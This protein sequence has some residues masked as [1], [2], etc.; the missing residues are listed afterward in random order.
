VSGLTSDGVGVRPDL[1]VRL[2]G[3]KQLVVDA[4]A[5]LA[6]FLDAS[7]E[8]ASDQQREERLR[9]HGRALRG[10]VDALAAR[11][12][13][14]AFS[15]APDVV[16]CFVPGESMLAAA[17]DADPGLHEHGLARGVVLA[18]PGTLLAL[19]RTV[20]FTWQQ[21]ALAGNARELFEVGRELYARLGTLGS[22][23][24]KLGRTLHRAV[25]DYNALVGTLERR[26]LVTARRI[27]ELEVADE[28]IPVTQPVEVT[29]RPLTAG[30]L[31]EDLGARPELL[32]DAGRA[33]P[34]PLFEAESG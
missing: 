21:E 16:V 4:K 10:H 3:G 33:R 14:R 19:L 26:V 15:P 32:D 24:A 22:H 25:E 13:S 17:L 6:A 18:G 11:D 8:G 28:P 34:V 29:P 5:P 2:P 20:A 12:Y 1:L 30:E 9:A 27:S 23:S 7:A 31:L